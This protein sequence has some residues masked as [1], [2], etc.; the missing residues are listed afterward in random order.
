MDAEILH[1]IDDEAIEYAWE[2]GNDDGNGYA[3]GDETDAIDSGAVQAAIGLPYIGWLSD[4][5]IAVYSDGKSMVAV[6]DNDGPWAVGVSWLIDVA[7]ELN[8]K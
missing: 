4:P 1:D 2:T 7:N 8:S 3:V 5:W 6:K